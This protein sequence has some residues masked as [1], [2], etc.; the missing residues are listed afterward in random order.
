MLEQP[1][2]RRG[3][4]MDE[5]IDVLRTIWKGGF[6]EHHGTFYDFGPLSMS[7]APPASVP[8][9][10]G[11]HSEPALA[12]AATVGDGWMGVYYE[13]DELDGYLK[14]LHQL[15]DEAGRA[16]ETSRS[17]RRCW[18]CPTKDVIERLEAMG[19]TTLLTSAWLM[20]GI[21]NGVA[22]A[23]RRR[24]QPVRRHVH[25]SVSE[26]D[27]AAADGRVPGRRGRATRDRLLECT[28]EMLTANSYRDVKVIDI[29]REAGTSP[30]TFYQ[31]FPDVEAA[32]LVLAEQ[33]A[34]ESELA[35][36]ARDGSWRGKAGLRHR[37]SGWSTRSS[38]SG[39]RT[40][41]CCAS[42]TSPPR[43]ATSASAR[44]ACGCLPRSPTRS[45]R[46]W[47][48]SRRRA[49]TRPT[50]TPRAT[51]GALVS[52]LAHVAAHRYGFEFWGIRTADLR[53]S[54]ARTIFWSVTGQKPP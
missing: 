54:M 50:S 22:P 52:M 15:L 28:G 13:L 8:I 6:V 11:G 1:Y 41:R 48:T 23:E 29:A 3:K 25:P 27:A 45:P 42:S 46:S 2:K 16:T 44:S 14:R 32:I 9:L 17:P 40:G 18:R 7:P 21:E 10:I 30:A 12:R 36:L 31:Y 38:S 24:P 47:V 43:R 19:V 20:E 33:M 5:M 49:A 35:A 34:H 4:R 53:R 37:A 39:S 51:A 26:L